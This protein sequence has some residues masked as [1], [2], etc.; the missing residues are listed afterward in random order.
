M[1]HI[2]HLARRTTCP[3]AQALT[4]PPGLAGILDQGK[5][6]PGRRRAANGREGGA[7][8]GDARDSK[9]QQQ[10]IGILALRQMASL[11]HDVPDITEYAKIAGERARKT[12]SIDGI[13]RDQ[14]GKE[15]LCDALGGILF[16]GG[17]G[18][19]LSQIAGDRYP[20]GFR[21]IDET[22]RKVRILRRQRRLDVAPDQRRIVSKNGFKLKICEP[23]GV[24]LGNQN[25][26]GIRG[27]W[28]QHGE[29]RRAD[30]RRRHRAARSPLAH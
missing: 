19:A 6:D 30:C 12:G 27:A 10:P 26:S 23:D 1:P 4:E 25:G 2:H 5:P 14:P 28:R 3:P 8:H 17:L 16:L 13:A 11:P 21:K 15:S 7:G 9:P 22:T 24:I 20:P 29:R 18:D